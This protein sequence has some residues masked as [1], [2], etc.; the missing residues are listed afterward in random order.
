MKARWLKRV[1]YSAA[2]PSAKVFGFVV[3]V[4]VLL[5]YPAKVQRSSGKGNFL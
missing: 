5:Q 2:I 3:F 4:E 1:M